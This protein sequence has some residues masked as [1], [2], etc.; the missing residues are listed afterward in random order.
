MEDT[1][2]NAEMQQFTDQIL[3]ALLPL[4]VQ[5]GYNDADKQKFVDAITKGIPLQVAF[6]ISPEEMEQKYEKAKQS[7]TIGDFYDACENFSWL[8]TNNHTRIKYWGGLAKSLEGLK[9]YP[10][11]IDVYSIMALLTGCNEPLPFYCAALCYMH[12]ND[13][14]NAISAF[15]HAKAFADS[16][17]DEHRILVEKADRYIRDIENAQFY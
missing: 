16:T 9:E 2:V 4:A 10:K 8:C 3:E 15:E 11:A 5:A 13:A 7:L 12:L 14:E 1:A 17:N 6:N